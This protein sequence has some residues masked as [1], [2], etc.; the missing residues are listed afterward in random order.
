M[1]V[2]TVCYNKAKIFRK[3]GFETLSKPPPASYE[4]R[5]RGECVWV[6]RWVRTGWPRQDVG[7][8]GGREGS[9]PAARRGWNVGTARGGRGTRS[10]SAGGGARTQQRE[11]DGLVHSHAHSLAHFCTQI[12][13]HRAS[14]RDNLGSFSNKIFVSIAECDI[15]SRDFSVSRLFSIF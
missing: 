2:F 3:Q 13:A 6:G 15:S 5:T 11:S 7:G 12:I 4:V 1:H 10:P 9:L 14:I 8:V